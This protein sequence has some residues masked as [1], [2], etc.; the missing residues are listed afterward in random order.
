MA[1]AVVRRI[2]ND[3]GIGDRL[4]VASAAIGDYHVGETAD[5]RTI[6]VLER[7]GFDAQHHRAK[8]F[9][10]R[11][12]DIVDLV[13][14]CDRGQERVLRS[15][16]WDDE[17]RSKIRLLRAFDPEAE[18]LDIPDPYYSDASFFEHVLHQI[19]SSCTKLMQQISPA[20]QTPRGN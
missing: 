2:A 17:Q 8:Q 3:A 5:Q 20:L 9:K 10:A 15:M 7:H 18:S 1:E 16:A 6:D 13:I 4:L 19:E 12:F 14:A 11:W